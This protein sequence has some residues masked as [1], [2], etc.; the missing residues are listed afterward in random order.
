V[1]AIV[2]AL[3]SHHHEIWLAAEQIGLSAAFQEN[4]APQP[5]VVEAADPILRQSATSI[6]VLSAK[7]RV[8]VESRGLD[9]TQDSWSVSSP[10]ERALLIVVQ[11]LINASPAFKASA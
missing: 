10:D 11:D 9:L 5:A 7:A 3:H 6:A 2:T 4:A 1:Q 8:L